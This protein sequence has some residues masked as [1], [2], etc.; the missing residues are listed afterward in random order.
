MP[1]AVQAGLRLAL[2]RLVKCCGMSYELREEK[3]LDYRG[4]ARFTHFRLHRGAAGTLQ[5]TVLDGRP[6]GEFPH[7]IMTAIVPRN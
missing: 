1:P 3:E 6:Q 4:P 5:L 7:L 2:D